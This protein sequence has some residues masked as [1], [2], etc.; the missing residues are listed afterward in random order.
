M[1]L[2]EGLDNFSRLQLKGGVLEVEGEIQAF[3]IGS[4]LNADTALVH[5]EKANPAFSGIYSVINQ[6][7]IAN[8]WADTRFINREDDMGLPGLRQAKERYHPLRMI[9]KFIVVE[10]PS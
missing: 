7:F 3:A 9:E 2:D 1:A 5:F 10:V 6:Q 4:R 8:E